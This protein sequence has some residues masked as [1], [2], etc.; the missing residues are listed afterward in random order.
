MP[1]V[2]KEIIMKKLSLT[3]AAVVLS[4]LPLFADQGSVV[5]DPDTGAQVTL[6]VLDLAKLTHDKLLKVDT[7][8]VRTNKIC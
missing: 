2:I 5:T 8:R 1:K 6:S 4:S 3:V 7:E